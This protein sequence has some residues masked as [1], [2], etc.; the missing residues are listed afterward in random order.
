MKT[1]SHFS[2][3]DSPNWSGVVPLSHV[4]WNSFIFLSFAWILSIW[5]VN[6][7]PWSNH[8]YF[9][10][11][12]F[13][14]YS[15]SFT[16]LSSPLSQRHFCLKLLCVLHESCD[17]LEHLSSNKSSGSS[18]QLSVLNNHNHQQRTESLNSSE[19]Q[20]APASSIWPINTKAFFLPAVHSQIQVCFWERL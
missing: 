19:Q 1:F 3:S 16:I 13:S 17:N 20:V 5:T 15:L 7:K 4:F 11:V 12:P 18:I 14:H 6:I 8:N 2:S 10:T 9:A